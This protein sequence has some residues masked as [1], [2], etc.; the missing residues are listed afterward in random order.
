MLCFPRHPPA[1]QPARHTVGHPACTTGNRPIKIWRLCLTEERG[2]DR[3]VSPVARIRKARAKGGAGP[4]GKRKTGRRAG[5]S[6]SVGSSKQAG[7]A[8]SS[9]IAL[10]CEQSGAVSVQRPSRSPVPVWSSRSSTHLIGRD[11][12]VHVDHPVVE[13]RHLLSR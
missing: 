13:D 10:A 12:I 6:G 7:L 4:G 1:L 5:G 3:E 11:V 8:A 9:M 2:E